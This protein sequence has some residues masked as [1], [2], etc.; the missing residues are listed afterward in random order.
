MRHSNLAVCWT[1]AV[2]AGLILLIMLGCQRENTIGNDVRPL[3]V[4]PSAQTTAIHSTITT[5]FIAI[6][7][8]AA[9][10]NSRTITFEFGSNYSDARFIC[11]LNDDDPTFCASPKTFT[12]LR[13]GDYKFR[14][15][16]ISST[17][18][19][20][21]VGVTHQWR[22]DTIPPSTSLAATPTANDAILFALSAS[23]PN[24]TFICT[25]DNGQALP[26]T[27]PISV[28]GL[29]PG[30]HTFKAQAVD[31]AT[32]VDP[33]GSQYTFEFTAQ[34]N[35]Q[36]RITRVAPTNPYTA[37]TQKAIDFESNHSNATFV[38][39]LNGSPLSACTPTKTYSSLPDSAYIFKVHAVDAFGVKDP[40]GA[41]HSWTVDTTPAVGSNAQGNPTSTSITVT[42][43][44][45]EPATTRLF[46]GVSPSVNREVADDGVLKTQHSVRLTGLSSNTVYAIEPAGHDRAAN[47]HKMTRLTVRTLR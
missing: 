20:D 46:W 43:T 29:A 27:T 8:P 44:T 1:K 22:V 30:W 4:K 13:D 6:A 17:G 9:I 42:W 45:N 15:Y 10:N 12:N 26:C 39:S 11:A 37:Q 16:A 28:S 36:T 40:V 7:P 2:V 18:G 33:V 32:N 41:S 31:E 21:A 3:S 19:T 23:E 25:I 47:P 24:C 5:F 35:L 34:P 38:C 14:V